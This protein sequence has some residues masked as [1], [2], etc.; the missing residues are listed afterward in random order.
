MTKLKIRRWGEYPEL[1]RELSVIA[2]V[3]IGRSK[4]IWK[5]T[6]KVKWTEAEVREEKRCYIPLA[7]KM[8]EGVPSQGI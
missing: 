5:P 2:K 7:L 8:E 4:R 3:F 6:E 1:R